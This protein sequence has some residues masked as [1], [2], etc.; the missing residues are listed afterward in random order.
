MTAALA[1]THNLI[2]VAPGNPTGD[3]NRQSGPQYPLLCPRPSTQCNLSEHGKAQPSWKG[4]QL[5]LANLT[6]VYTMANT[7]SM[8]YFYLTHW[9]ETVSQWGMGELDG[10][11]LLLH[12]S[13]LWHILSL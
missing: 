1:P 11:T 8:P 9:K 12:D 7:E 5:H 10:Q 13:F 3:P 2:E 4:A 6:T